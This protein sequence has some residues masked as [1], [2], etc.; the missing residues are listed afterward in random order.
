MPR[1]TPAGTTTPLCIAFVEPVAANGRPEVLFLADLM[2]CAMRAP[3]DIKAV[4]SD[5]DWEAFVGIAQTNRVLLLAARGLQER[6]L[7]PPESVMKTIARYRALTL[8]LNGAN[9]VTLRGVIEAFSTAQIDVIGLKGPIALSALHKDAFIRPSTDIDLLVHRRD[10]KRAGE[11]IKT[12]G[13]MAPRGA[14]TIWW[15]TFLGEQHYYAEGKAPID[16]HHRIQQPDCP[17]PRSLEAFWKDRTHASV[18]TAQVAIL[19]PKHAALLSCVSLTKAIAQ[20]EAA[21]AHAWDIAV[22]IAS[23]STAQLDA[24]VDGARSMGLLNTLRL[25]LRVVRALFGVSVMGISADSAM[26]FASDA[27]M[28]AIVLAPEGASAVN[29]PRMRLLASLSDNSLDLARNILWAAGARLALVTTPR[30]AVVQRLWSD[31]LV[32]RDQPG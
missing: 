17:A 24:L 3:K 29:S 21:G 8:S 9:L 23:C 12:S 30:R 2:R 32:E 18:G 14:D 16:L 15:R 31:Q 4:P 27:D 28:A 22:Y 1:L 5:I 10:F 13:F 26:A 19:S 7:A 20:R 6:G 25:G 11:L